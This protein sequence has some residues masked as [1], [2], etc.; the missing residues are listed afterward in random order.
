MA[1]SPHPDHFMFGSRVGFSG[2]AD[3]VALFSG[4]TASGTLCEFG[5]HTYVEA[6]DM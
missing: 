3:R 4:K 5:F 2:A 1:M 6:D